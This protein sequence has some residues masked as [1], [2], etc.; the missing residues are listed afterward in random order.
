M[1]K[2]LIILSLFISSQAFSQEILI[3]LTDRAQH[4]IDNGV[5]RW[6]Y[7]AYNIDAFNVI[8]S[9]VP[10]EDGKPKVYCGF[11]CAQ[12][13]RSTKSNCDIAFTP[14]FNRNTLH[15]TYKEDILSPALVGYSP[16]VEFTCASSTT[17]L[18]N[19]KLPKA[20]RFELKD[21]TTEFTI[22]YTDEKGFFIQE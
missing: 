17:Q 7:G 22:D 14:S 6:W 8:L 9:L 21:G 12:P 15:I 5:D 20:F 18:A 11:R 16:E 4:K 3:H 13:H 10:L 19:I 2:F 1:K